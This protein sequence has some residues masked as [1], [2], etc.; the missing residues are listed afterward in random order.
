V[1]T[2]DVMR[3]RIAQPNTESA[4]RTSWAALLG[5]DL[6]TLYS[7]NSLND[8]ESKRNKQVSARRFK[9]A[10]QLFPRQSKEKHNL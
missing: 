5:S 1:K 10:F 8:T 3:F 9:G 2:A 6:P 4:L 7:G